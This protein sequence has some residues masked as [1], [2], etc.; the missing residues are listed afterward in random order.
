MQD[1]KPNERILGCKYNAVRTV[2][3]MESKEHR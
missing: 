3:I 2:M 1:E